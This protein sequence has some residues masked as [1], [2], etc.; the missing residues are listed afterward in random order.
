V[1]YLYPFDWESETCGSNL[2]KR[3]ALGKK[4]WEFPATFGGNVI[5]RLHDHVGSDPNGGGCDAGLAGE[6][7]FFFWGVVLHF[8]TM[9]LPGTIVIHYFQKLGIS[10]R[11]VLKI[12]LSYLATCIMSDM[13]RKI[14]EKVVK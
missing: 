3:W 8:S 4:N 10:K 13:G 5:S 6:V 7:F 2:A 14:K 9:D 11:M 12:V 1:G